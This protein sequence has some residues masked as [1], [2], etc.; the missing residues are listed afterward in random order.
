L[1]KKIEQIKEHICYS[2]DSV[3]KLQYAKGKLSSYEELLQDVK[4]DLQTE[5]KDGTDNQT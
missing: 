3:D 4:G 2:V 1:N 5:D